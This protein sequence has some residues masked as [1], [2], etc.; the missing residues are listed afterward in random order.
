MIRLHHG[1][2]WL[3]VSP[4]YARLLI[5]PDVDLAFLGDFWWLYAPPKT[6]GD[7]STKAFPSFDAAAL[8]VAR[9]LKQI[10]AI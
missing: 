3:H 10:G 1:V 8:A 9:A 7:R 2:A 4:S 6:P 5:A